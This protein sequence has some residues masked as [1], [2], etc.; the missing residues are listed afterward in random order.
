[1][2]R[3]LYEVLGVRKGASTDEIKK[4]YRK[5]ASKLH[6]DRNP[7]NRDAE[8]KFKDVNHAYDVLGDPKKRSLYDE[9]GEEALREG[10]DADRVR[11]YRQWADQ[12]RTAGGGRG[13]SV[14][15]SPGSF[16]IEDIFSG[17]IPNG[18]GGQG[19]IGDMFGDLLGGMG[20]RRRGA[21]RGQDVESEIT[22]DFVEAVRGGTFTLQ[23]S[24]LEQPI[25][26]RI[27]PGAEEGSRV[28][29]PGQG[30]TGQSGGARGDLL[31]R[32]HVRPHPFFRREHADLHLN[33]P[34]TVGEAYH[35][36]R[37]RV[38]TPEGFVTLKVPEHTQSGNV[39]RLKGKGIAK[40]RAAS[41]EGADPVGDLYVHFDVQLPTA[42][43]SE[44]K[45]AIEQLES[46]FSGDVRAKLAF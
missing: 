29:I 6:P 27:P 24:Q 8:S 23:T 3:D 19:G 18:A 28:R 10:F 42:E 26:V 46:A 30:A 20:R 1:M 25:T 36:A 37:V 22:I 41:E 5:L 43:T 4:Q 31:L 9:F 13:F 21:S 16:R 33:L 45:K 38:P 44:V 12:Q 39:L 32:I 35:G 7:G 14:S 11:Q 17:A 40:R 2:A 34:I 15:G